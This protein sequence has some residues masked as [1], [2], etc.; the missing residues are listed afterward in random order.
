LIR[1]AGL[2]LLTVAPLLAASPAPAADVR[3]A[4]LRVGIAVEPDSI[5]PHFHNFGGNKSFDPNVF[6]ALTALDAQDHLTPGLALSWHLVDDTTWEFRLR[7]GVVFS[8]GSTFTADDVAFTLQRVPNVPTS[9]ADFSEYVKPIA[10]TEVVDPLTIRLHTSA[11][12]P[13]APNYL[14]AISIVSRK[15]GAGASTA[16]YNTGKAAIGTGPFRLVSWARGDRIILE[17]NDHYWGPRPIWTRVELHY[18]SNAAA[19]LAAL[20][21]GDVALIDRV[22]LQDVARVKQDPRFTLSVGPSNDLVG[23]VFDVIDHSSPKITDNDGKPLLHNPLRD[24][25]VRQAID[26]AIDRNAIRDR[27]M[28]GMAAPDNQYMRPGQFG[29]DPALPPL[30][31]DPAGAK[32]LLAEAGFPTGFHLM[33]DCDNDRFVNDSMICQGVAQM[34][35]HAGLTA[36]PEAMPHAV[37][38]P[39]ANKHAFSLFTYFWTLDTPEPSVMLNSQLVTPDPVHGHGQFNRGV[40]SNATFDA[41]LAQA[42]STLDNAAREALLIKATD[43]AIRDVAVLPLHHQFNVEAMVKAIHRP[44]RHDGRILPEEITEDAAKGE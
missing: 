41:T 24:L 20:L 25:R 40:W 31:V 38:V 44:P 17:R 27:L 34:L 14:S 12:F 30:H 32:R 1:R 26:M 8:D 43:I 21:S 3:A 33:V 36:T 15:Y 42:V 18:I 10:R 11:P 39:L 37:W 35:T 2:I 6:D 28:N 22:S 7:P 4:D 9:V 13:L 5:D 16:D 19:R 29:Y 23:L